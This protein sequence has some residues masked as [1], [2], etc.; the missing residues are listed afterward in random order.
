MPR[1]DIL[2]MNPMTRSTKNKNSTQYDQKSNPF[3]F[4]NIFITFIYFLQTSVF[5][6]LVK[7]MGFADL[8]SAFII[9][10]LHFDVV[11]W[12]LAIIVAAYLFTKAYAF[13]GDFASILDGIT[14][15]YV[16]LL[17]FGLHTFLAYIFVIYL[18]QK[19]IMSSLA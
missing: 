14:G 3:L 11:G 5:M 15:L 18:L 10:L 6:V 13:R 7:I 9:L 1:I 8:L 16:L 4:L 17:M 12:R 19:G 2:T